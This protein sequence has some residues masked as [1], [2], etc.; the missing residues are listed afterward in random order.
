MPQS[1]WRIISASKVSVAMSVAAMVVATAP[2]TWSRSAVRTY[3][4]KVVMCGWWLASRAKPPGTLWRSRAL[5]ARARP[6]VSSSGL[7]R[8]SIAVRSAMAFPFSAIPGGGRRPAPASE[9]GRPVVFHADHSPA[10][11]PGR[12]QGLLGCLRVG[13]L[14]VAV[15][16]IHQDGER[17]GGEHLD[18]DIGVSAGEHGHPAGLGEDVL[19]LARPESQAAEHLASAGDR[20]VLVLAGRRGA[21]HV[22][23]EDAPGL[24]GEDPHEVPAPARAHKYPELVS[25]QQ[26]EQLQH[27][28]VHQL[29]VPDFEPGLGNG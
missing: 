18:V 16:V 1:A 27:R 7:I 21:D 12:G 2:K 14:A 8:M 5:T 29:G 10:Q 13:V 3:R 28:L 20:A 25:L 17:G 19:G 11:L 24:L 6:T 22:L 26:V 23:L 9:D 15:V 4:C